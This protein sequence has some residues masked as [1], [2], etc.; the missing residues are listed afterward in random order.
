MYEVKD[1]ANKAKVLAP[2]AFPKEGRLPG[3][4][5]AVAETMENKPVKR[6]FISGTGMEML[7]FKFTVRS[8]LVM[9][10]SWFS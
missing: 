1:K 5:K 3:T 2:P 8:R 7:V 9:K 4:L 10:A 6:I